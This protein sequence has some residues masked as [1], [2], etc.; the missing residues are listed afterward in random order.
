MVVS[1]IRKIIEIM[2]KQILFSKYFDIFQIIKYYLKSRAFKNS[3]NL[4]IYG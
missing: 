4:G 2:E 3:K 1:K